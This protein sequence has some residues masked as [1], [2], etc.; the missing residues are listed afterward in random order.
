MTR[1]E[2]IFMLFSSLISKVPGT[3]A[4]PSYEHLVKISEGI[5]NV[6]EHDWEAETLV[7]IAWWESGIRESIVS[8]R[9]KS[10]MGAS[11]AFQVI[12]RN[13]TE[14]EQS[15]S[16]NLELQAR[17]AL[18]RVRESKT[19][20]ANLGVTGADSLGGYTSGKCFKNNKHSRLRYGTGS[21]L[22]YLIGR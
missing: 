1:Y 14:A 16:S 18:S 3:Y 5:D 6:A 20:C 8:C 2:A 15:C 12:P 9:R 10:S 17:L 22:S 21:A 13:A 19:W 7:R 4:K 11:G